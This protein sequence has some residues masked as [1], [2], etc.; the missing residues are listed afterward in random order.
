M[1]AQ[2]ILRVY[3]TFI[4][5]IHFF[6]IHPNGVGGLHFTHYIDMNTEIY[7]YF[8]FILH[9]LILHILY[10]YIHYMYLYV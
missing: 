10:T 2:M 1:W 7:V 6:P 3:T 9:V 4:Y 5:I 8:T